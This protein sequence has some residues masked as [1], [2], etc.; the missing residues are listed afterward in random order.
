MIR[1]AWV[2]LV[3][4]LATLAFGLVAI[5]GSLLRVRNR[6]LYYWATRS[7][8]RATLW[9]SGTPVV[10]HG[11]ERVDWN[12]PQILLSNHLS[13]YDIFAL[14]GVLPAPFAFVAKKELER[15]P[16]F[17]TA[18]KA[19]GHISIDR[20]DR[21]KAVASLRRAG[22]AIRRERTTVIIFPEGTRSRTGELQ[23]FKRGAFVL[24]L[25][26]GVPVVPVVVRKA[27]RF[28]RPGR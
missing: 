28:K 1:F 16:F 14:A 6:R 9:A 3:T 11:L 18:W 10:V 27:I 21:Q 22:E 7:W 19:A 25:E 13:T 12:A 24:S 15:I 20:S 23:P 17:G 5:V 2:A 4:A 26:S 8:S